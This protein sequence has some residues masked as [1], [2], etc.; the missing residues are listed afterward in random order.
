MRR[1]AVLFVKEPRAGRVKTRL[2]HEIGMTAAAGWFRHQSARLIRR[3]DDPRWQL[4]LAVTPDRAARESRV[5]PRHLPR[6]PQGPGDLGARMGRV[7]RDFPPGPVIIAGADVPELS[8][9]H[10]AEGFRLLGRHEAALGPATDGG[11]WM[12][13]LRRGARAVPAG[14]FRGVRWSSEHAM[15]DTVASLA[16]LDMGYGPVLRDVDET[17]DLYS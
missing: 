3:L 5:W 17:T 9:T 13:G 2:G 6:W 10:I 8:A 16:P 1:W 12:I 15:S 7:F 4:V 11:Y 14:L